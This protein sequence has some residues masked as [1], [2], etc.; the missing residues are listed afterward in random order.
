MR[1]ALAWLLG[2][3]WIV[4]GAYSLVNP[5]LFQSTAIRAVERSPRWVRLLSP[6]ATYFRSASYRW[7]TR[8][9]GALAIAMGGLILLMLAGGQFE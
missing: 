5:S 6:S 3:G 1:L 4:L 8:I 7:N 9:C 2:I